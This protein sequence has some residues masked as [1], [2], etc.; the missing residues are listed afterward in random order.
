[1]AHGCSLPCAFF[2]LLLQ[3]SNNGAHAYILRPAQSEAVF[4]CH[5]FFFQGSSAPSALFQPKAGIQTKK[6][7]NK[8]T[9]TR[10]S[11]AILPPGQKYEGANTPLSASA[12]P[13][14]AWPYTCAICYYR[15]SSSLA[16][17][18]YKRKGRSISSEKSITAKGQRD[19][20]KR[21]PFSQ[22]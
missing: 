18:S 20:I 9:D 1:M 19:G 22:K 12:P 10:L 7:A 21:V 3:K 16:A 4:I 5:A 11:R 2:V 17:G 13:E 6:P 15:L 14:R 8:S